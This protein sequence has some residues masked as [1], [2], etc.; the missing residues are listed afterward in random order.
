MRCAIRRRDGRDDVPIVRFDD[1]PEFDLNGIGVRGLAAPSRGASE[2]M[3]YR[4]E[5]LAGQRL[6]AHSHDHEEVFHVIDGAL[7][8][9]LDGDE[10]DLAGGDTVM[11]P[12][13]VMH[14]S[15]T[16]E[17]AAATLIAVMPVGTVVIRPDGERVSPPWGE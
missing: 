4:V 13:G 10:A 15:Y 6:P 7:T 2:A 16:R 14:F 3:T 17:D 11:V 5:L 8:V 12:P 1:A 9:S